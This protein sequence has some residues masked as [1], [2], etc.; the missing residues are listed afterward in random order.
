MTA[1]QRPRVGTP[2]PAG[3]LRRGQPARQ[4]QQRERIAARLGD[5][6]VAHPLVQSPGDHRLQQRASIAVA[7]APDHHLRKAP[8][9]L[10]LAG[11]P[12]REHQRHRL[13][14]EPAR[15]EGKDL[16]RGPIEPLRVIHHADERPLLGDLGQQA[17]HRQTHQEAIRRRSGREAER[18]AKRIALRTGQMRQVGAASVRR[19]D[20][21]RRT[22]AP[23]R[24]RRRPPARCGTLTRSPPGSPAT[25]SCRLPRRR[26]GPGP[27]SARLAHPPATDRAP[28][29]RY[30]GLAIPD[31]DADW[32]Y[33]LP[34]MMVRE[35]AD[36]E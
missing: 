8:Q 29:T 35:L 30:V 22:R 21:G 32:T 13:R 14:Q 6:P 10:L 31:H 24:T 4:L 11:L 12:Y 7:Q 36:A 15:H 25:R 16:C 3:Q 9:L 34:R 28:R 26:A 33:L 1:R 17:Q 27:G 19:A 18:R 20:A 2:E 5:D 23:S